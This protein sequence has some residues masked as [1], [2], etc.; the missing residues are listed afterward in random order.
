MGFG[1]ILKSVAGAAVNPIGAVMGLAGGGGG[2]PQAPPEINQGVIQQKNR[3]FDLYKQFKDKRP[4]LEQEAKTAATDQAKMD[5]SQRLYDT[6]AGANQR[7]MLNSGIRQKAEQDV[8]AESGGRLAKTLADTSKNFEAQ[9]QAL[10][11]RA[12][13]AGSQVQGMEQSRFNAL[14]EAQMNAKNQR[15]QAANSP[16]GIAAMPMSLMSKGLRLG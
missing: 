3:M 11:D 4:G 16:L 14:Y 15:A 2:D 13:N 10:E 5:L 12:F 8:A 7:G 9:Q 1:K 6:R